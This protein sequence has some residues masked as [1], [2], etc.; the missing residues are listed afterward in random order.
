MEDIVQY[1]CDCLQGYEG[2]NCQIDIDECGPE[3]VCSNGGECSQNTDTPGYICVC[4]EGYFGRNCERHCTP[5]PAGWRQ[6]TNCGVLEEVHGIR[7]AVNRR[8]DMCP[9][10]CG[11]EWDCG[12]EG[13]EARYDLYSVG[14]D[15]LP[16]RPPDVVHPDRSACTRCL[17]G[18]ILENGA[19][20]CT[21]CSDR[22]PRMYAQSETACAECVWP[23]V[24]SQAGTECHLCSPGQGIDN[25]T[26]SCTACEGRDRLGRNANDTKIHYSEGGQCVECVYPYVILDGDRTACKSCPNNEEPNV[27]RLGCSTCGEN[28]YSES[29]LCHVCHS[30]NRISKGNTCR[31]P[32][33]C[34]IGTHCSIN[35]TLAGG[36][37]KNSDCTACPVGHISTIDGTCEQ[38]DTDVQGK[39][40]KVANDLQSDCMSCSSGKMP[41]I[42]GSRCVACPENS[43]STH[44]IACED[45]LE[46]NVVDELQRSCTRCPAGTG[47]SLDRTSCNQCEIGKYS[48]RKTGQCMSCGSQVNNTDN[49]ACSDCPLPGQLAVDGQC[50]CAAGFY[51]A[52]WNDGPD[53]TGNAFGS[54]HWR[55]F[56]CYD[57]LT[58]KDYSR[59]DFTNRRGDE[60]ND[61]SQPDDVCMSCEDLPCIECSAGG[62][63]TIRPKY[64][65]SMSL[66]RAL[67]S[68]G[69]STFERTA[70][71]QI[72]VFRCHLNDTACTGKFEQPCV[73]GYTGFLCDT[74]NEYHKKVRIP[75]K[76]FMEYKQMC[77]KTGHMCWAR[78]VEMNSLQQYCAPFDHQ[79]S[80]EGHTLFD[81]DTDCISGR[82]WGLKWYIPLLAGFALVSALYIIAGNSAGAHT[83]TVFVIVAKITMCIGQIFAQLPELFAVTY[84]AKFMW[85]LM[86][87]QMSLLHWLSLL[88][89]GCV[90]YFDQF[91]LACT[92][93]LWLLFLIAALQLV[94]EHVDKFCIRLS[95]LDMAYQ[96]KHVQH[97]LG[98]AA[99]TTAMNFATIFL[100]YPQVSLV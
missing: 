3:G 81:G 84:P 41:A 1:A 18:W 60:L 90:D 6:V 24:V 31:P 57:H 91:K 45:C 39:Y 42:D 92:F 70:T 85:I 8:C 86:I 89:V 56:A 34:P 40:L 99:R 21:R 28:S 96:Q 25:S 64:A 36:C 2:S 59:S 82:T 19:S 66:Y 22:G 54:D 67:D 9:A 47:P 49:T 72:P 11:Q 80:R 48:T 38:C 79:L 71:R 65:L 87:I 51:R 100:V 20:N 29:G 13:N 97:I 94:L 43:F 50:V 74:C 15:C 62:A 83:L 4:V 63:V 33:I 73:D 76:Q 53:S 69:S 5:C 93:P 32:Y 75:D 12:A 77:N 55:A 46:P 88:D 10:Q 95:P 27:D 58:I 16:C 26:S 23:R 37:E 35:Q 30:P 68:A 17:P 14:D 44:G 98:L 7:Q 78:D 61:T 52:K